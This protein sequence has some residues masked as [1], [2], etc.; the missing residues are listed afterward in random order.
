MV[1]T[2]DNIYP[3]KTYPANG[4][5][6]IRV[7]GPVQ[8]LF[9]LLLLICTYEKSGIIVALGSRSISMAFGKFIWFAMIVLYAIDPVVTRRSFH[10]QVDFNYPLYRLFVVLVVVQTCA[11]LFGLI[12]APG[13]INISSEMYYF[14]QRAGVLVIP[15][16][17]LRYHVSRKTVL[18]FFLIS[19]V[20]HYIFI[21]LQFVSPSSYGSFVHAVNNPL[22]L[23][24][25]LGW[26]TSGALS[27]AFVGLQRTSNYGGFAAV[28]GLLALGFS[29]HKLSYKLL[30]WVMV[31]M[32]IFVALMGFSRSVLI[33]MII[34][35]IVY[36]KQRS[37]FSRISTYTK[38]VFLVVVG[39]VLFS[40]NLVTL[41]V[42][43][44]ASINGFYDYDGPGPYANVGKRSSDI[45]KLA[46]AK[47]GLRLFAQSPIVGWG[48]R[49]LGDIA[50]AN[51]FSRDEMDAIGGPN[52]QTHSYNLT[53][54]LSTGLIGF[55]AYWILSLRILKI[56]WKNHNRD[57]AIV[58]GLFAGLIVYNILYDAGS[59]EVFM[60]FNG[61]AAYYALTSCG[62]YRPKLKG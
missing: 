26:G 48:Q 49:R 39:I 60:C 61:V 17:A 44:V 29:S 42:K 32:A 40:L 37:L 43:Q 31:F 5:L 2:L 58:C 59:L 27:W 3:A 25:S 50:I 9:L 47:Y 53:L 52:G 13:K 57:Y 56:L 15:L 41:E 62:I 14:I 10:K 24:N 20:I 22:R 51:S 28:F 21:V 7:M 18:K 12:V 16:L 30:K 4:L 23:D 8:F 35:L 45:G 54:L 38:I 19:V 36:A 34:A 6:P 46:L 33:M 1:S 55:I 11:S